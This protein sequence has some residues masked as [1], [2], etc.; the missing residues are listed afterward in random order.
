MKENI[1]VAQSD[2]IKQNLANCLKPL[3]RKRK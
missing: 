3:R 2:V 1:L